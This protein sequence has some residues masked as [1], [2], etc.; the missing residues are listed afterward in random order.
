MTDADTQRLILQT[1]RR[2]FM[3]SG[4]RAVSTR[5]I[6]DACGLTQ[7]ALYHYFATKQDLY[8]AVMIDMLSGMQSVLD[9]IARRSETVQERLSRVALFLLEQSHEGMEMMLHDIVR[10]LG[11]TA[12]DALNQA[13]YRAMIQPVASIFAEGLAAGELIAPAAGMEAVNLTFLLLN[14]L[15][16]RPAENWKTDAASPAASE[17]RELLALHANTLVNLLLNGLRPR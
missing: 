10:E 13:F 14:L 9:R 4:Y 6:A 17:Q 5:R 15:K 1:A 12:R 16:Y 8:V 2:F 3:E 7:P 11:T